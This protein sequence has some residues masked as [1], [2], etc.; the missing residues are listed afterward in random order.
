MRGA[1][2]AAAGLAACG[3][4]SAGPGA[5]ASNSGGPTL[6]VDLATATGR[7]LDDGAL[8]EAE[9][10]SGDVSADR[11]A[12]ARGTGAAARYVL[13]ASRACAED[14][15]ADASCDM[16]LLEVDE[17]RGAVVHALALADGDSP[18]HRDLPL[19]MVA[20]G[21]GDPDGDGHQDLVVELLQNGEPQPAVGAT[22]RMRTLLLDPATFTER[23]TLDLGELA[24]ADTLP[25]CTATVT[26]ADVS[27]DQ[28]PDL[29]V[30]TRCQP[31]YCAEASDEERASELYRGVCEPP[32]ADTFVA[33]LATGDGSYV[34]HAP[35]PG[36]R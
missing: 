8:P 11:V 36:G 20:V 28:R 10:T 9:E 3:R 23:A 34:E 16:T 21:L 6:C 19:T 1:L 26:V 18:V 7:A 29:V 33:H 2:L 17:A 13:T 15:D 31:G 4:G 35:P 22:D 5:I 24:E 32:I 12:V 14:G 27:C 30:R 25:T